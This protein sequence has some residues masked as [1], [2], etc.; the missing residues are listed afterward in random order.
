MNNLTLR[1]LR[2]FEAL[3]QTGHFGRAADLCAISQP[4]LSLQIKELEDTLQQT[5]EKLTNLQKQ[6]G[7]AQ[8]AVLSPEQQAE[9]ENFRKKTTET[10]RDLKDLR[11]NL[12]EE[13]EQ[14]QFW[15]KLINIGT[16]PLLVVIL[17]V[18]LAVVRRRRVA[19]K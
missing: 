19:A 8:S 5:Q 10:K 3:T 1:Q 7:A 14:L 12:R 4:A 6:R 2:Y 18:A 15:T 11:K 16:V 13:S 17:G 9:I